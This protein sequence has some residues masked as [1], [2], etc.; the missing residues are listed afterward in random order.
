MGRGQVMRHRHLPNHSW[1][2]HGPISRSTSSLSLLPRRSVSSMINQ[3]ATLIR[4]AQCSFT[5]AA[6]L[7]QRSAAV[8]NSKPSYLRIVIFISRSYHTHIKSNKLLHSVFDLVTSQ[9]HPLS[10]NF[11]PEFGDV[12]H[13][14][15]VFRQL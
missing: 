7:R 4:A 13:A 11:S 8:N 15:R 12:E 2:L 9:A 5:I 14:C 6:V 10:Q 3:Q 1:A